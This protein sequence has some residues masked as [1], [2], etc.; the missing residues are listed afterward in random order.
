MQPTLAAPQ[1]E[2]HISTPQVAL[3]CPL[4]E[5]GTLKRHVASQKEQVLISS[6]EGAPSQTAWQGLQK[7]RI[8]HLVFDNDDT[9]LVT[10]TKWDTLC[11]RS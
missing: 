8:L 1:T 3:A 10:V 9:I 7:Q 5:G 11:S 6:T 2:L 4:R